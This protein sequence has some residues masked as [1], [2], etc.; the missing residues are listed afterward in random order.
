MILPGSYANGFAPRDGQPLYPGLWQGCVGA[1]APCLGPTGLTLRD[2][3]GNANHGTLTRGPTFRSQGERYAL[4]FD[5][6]DDT[7]EMT[8]KNHPTGAAARTFSAWFRV[9]DNSVSRYIFGSGIDAGSQAFSV[10]VGAGGSQGQIYL[11]TNGTDAS[12]ATG[13]FANSVWNHVAI[14]YLA[15]TML[16]YINGKSTAWASGGTATLATGA[17]NACLG[18][19]IAGGAGGSGSH[20]GQ[21]DDVRIYNRVISE[22]EIRALA[23]RRGIA[24]E[25]AARRRS[26]S[27]VQFNRRRRLLVGAHS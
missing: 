2:W 19:Y 16:L 3:S 10:R 26:F 6:S 27:A 8:A 17:A 5:G 12:T 15:P 23:S 18:F 4:N 25:I 7:V 9:T 14:A 22:K 24:Y 1:W 20:I 11:Y 13:L 21:I